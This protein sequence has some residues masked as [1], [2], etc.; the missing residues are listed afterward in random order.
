MESKILGKRTRSGAITAPS[1]RHAS[2]VEFNDDKFESSL[3]S[4]KPRHIQPSESPIVLN[5]H[6][7]IAL[8]CSTPVKQTPRT[9]PVRSTAKLKKE[10]ESTCTRDYLTEDED[11]NLPPIQTPTPRTPRKR[12]AL[13][14]KIPATPKHKVSVTGQ[15]ITPRSSRF[16]YTPGGSI[17]TVYSLARQAFTRSTDP[18]PLIGRED[19]KQR[20]LKFVNG[21]LTKNS[22][23][24]IYVSGPPGTGK[25]A[26]VSEVVER[27]NASDTT[28][29]SFIN[30]MSI[31]TSKDLYSHLLE[32]SGSSA[33]IYEGQE[34]DTLESIYVPRKHTKKYFIVTLDEID[35]I[36]TLDSEILYKLFELALLKGSHLILIGIANALDLTDRF[37][38]RLK[39]R[40]LKPQLLSFLPYTAKQI[41]AVIESRLISLMPKESTIQDYVPFLHPSAIELCSRKV[42]SQNGDLRKAFEICRRAINAIESEV[43]LNHE[44]A[45][46]ENI[47]L[48]SPSK[49]PLED[50]LNLSKPHLEM[51]RKSLA[52]SLT[53]LT[54]ET[55]P[56]ASISHINKIT[57]SIFGNGTNQ[58]LKAL[59]LQQKAT[60][61]AL[62]ALEKRKR[63][64]L[65]DKFFTPSKS[66]EVTLTVKSL[67][68]V[69]C[70][71]CKRDQILHPLSNIEFKDLIGS[72]ESLSLVSLT[73][74]S[75][76][77]QNAKIGRACKFRTGSRA[78]DEKGI[79]SCVGEA[80]VAKAIE[81]LGSSILKTILAGEGLD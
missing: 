46:N 2:L 16:P 9:R 68:Q 48:E 27:F 54:V 20:L 30:C 61:C 36:L 38:P 10:F 44:R 60:L 13:S 64:N 74:S 25:S 47:L 69:Y 72:L 39:A 15:P 40:D 50:N 32:G 75:S 37:L 78:F 81:G 49:K 67:Y 23:G 43:K 26:L 34:I 19:E 22:G 33:T 11:E 80:D 62:L 53:S 3:L 77:G 4:R 8:T 35:R 5:P 59:N 31:R 63:Q 57:S 14:N 41:K 65:A 71:L 51:V 58:R 56:R 76:V 21:C 70:M 45:L 7:N 1:K 52:E 12:D 42:S 17:F 29:K 66:K 28:Q 73:G 6:C 79:N 18:G 24:C 55:A